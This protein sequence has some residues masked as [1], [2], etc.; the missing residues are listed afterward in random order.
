LGVQAELVFFPALGD[1]AGGEAE[2]AAQTPDEI[3]RIPVA[4]L[5]TV[6]GEFPLRGKRKVD[7]LLDDEILRLRLDHGGDYSTALSRDSPGDGNRF[8]ALT[9]FFG[10]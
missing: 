6:N 5:E 2:T 9:A 7:H 8:P 1:P 10:A 3:G 4:F